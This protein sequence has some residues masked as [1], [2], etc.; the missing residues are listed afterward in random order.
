MSGSNCCFLLCIQVSQEK[1]KVVWYSPLFKNF[2]RFVVIYT[3]KAFSVVHEEE[4]H[5]FWYCL[6]FSF[7]QWMLIQWKMLPTSIGSSYLICFQYLF[8]FSKPVF[9][10][11]FF[12]MLFEAFPVFD[13]FIFKSMPI[14]GSVC[15]W[16]SSLFPISSFHAYFFS[17]QVSVPSFLP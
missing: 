6:A 1:G 13:A 17:S 2:P 9:R 15:P 3:V 5:C 10:N 11:I 8:C 16:L 14:F 4:I 12:K 7:I